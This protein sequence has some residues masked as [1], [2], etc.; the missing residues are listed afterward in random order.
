M[1][2]IEKGLFTL[3]EDHY[4]KEEVKEG[5]SLQSLGLGASSKQSESSTTKANSKV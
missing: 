4:K 5:L 3:H 2:Q 1:K